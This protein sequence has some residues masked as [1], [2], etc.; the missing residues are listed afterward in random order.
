MLPTKEEIEILLETFDGVKEGVVDDSCIEYYFEY[1]SER[2][3][4]LNIIKKYI[5]WEFKIIKETFD[6]EHDFDYDKFKLDFISPDGLKFR[7]KGKDNAMGNLIK[8]IKQK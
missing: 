3:D 8:N 5:G 6:A 1:I 2:Q 7:I 4:H